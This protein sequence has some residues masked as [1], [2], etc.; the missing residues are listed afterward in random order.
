M[1]LRVVIVV[2]SSCLEKRATTGP[3]D[4]WTTC[5]LQVHGIHDECLRKYG[6]VNV[7]RYCTEVFDYLP[8]AALVAEKDFCLRAGLSPSINTLDQIRTINR[9]QV[10]TDQAFS[11]GSRLS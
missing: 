3:L 9:K 1:W 4:H 8:L 10:C 11:F 7:W 5:V 6:T 2:L